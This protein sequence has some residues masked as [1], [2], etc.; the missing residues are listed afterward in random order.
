MERGRTERP[1]GNG[2]RRI[3]PY[4]LITRLDPTGPGHPPVPEHRFVARSADGER[5]VSLAA[6]RDA[7][8]NAM[9]DRLTTKVPAA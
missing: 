7:A 1:S 8:T 4:H 2:P 5:T 6:F 3:G 9:V